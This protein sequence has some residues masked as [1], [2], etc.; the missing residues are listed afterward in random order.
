[1]WVQTEKETPVSKTE[2]AKGGTGVLESLEIQNEKAPVCSSIIGYK[3]N[4]LKPGSSLGYHAHEG[5]SETIFILSGTC[6]YEDNEHRTYEL[7]AGDS[8]YCGNGESHRV[9]CQGDEPL[10]FMA[11]ILKEN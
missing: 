2:K 7:H 10:V 1:M 3:R 5:S 4:T 8:A 6:A 9:A 11:L